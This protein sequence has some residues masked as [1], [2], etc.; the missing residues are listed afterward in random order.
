MEKSNEKT[1]GIIREL[2]AS[3]EMDSDLKE[4]LCRIAFAEEYG[5]LN[6]LAGYLHQM[7]NMARLW[8]SNQVAIHTM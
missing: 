6:D 1:I 5:S 4:I 7:D 2:I 8:A 3:D